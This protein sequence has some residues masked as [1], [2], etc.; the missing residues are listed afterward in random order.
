VDYKGVPNPEH[1]RV[2]LDIH[3]QFGNRASQAGS[4]RLK[5]YPTVIKGGEKVEGHDDWSCVDDFVAAGLLEW[6]GTGV[7]P[8]FALTDEG[9]KVSALLRRHRAEGGKF[10]EFRYPETGNGDA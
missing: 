6:K 4:T 3:P 9:Y 2:D 8:V 1:M 10:S 7:N 5:K